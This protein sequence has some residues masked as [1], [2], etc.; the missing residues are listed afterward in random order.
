LAAVCATSGLTACL[1]TG[2]RV[3]L[4]PASSAVGFTPSSDY[5][6]MTW[7]LRWWPWSIGHGV[8]PFETKLLW[9]PQGF[10]TFW[11]TTIPVPSLLASPLTLTAGPLVAYNVLMLAAI[12]LAAG[13][14][15]LLCIE[16]TG[17]FW[18]SFLGGLAF[19]LCPYMLGHTAAQHLNLAFVFPVPLLVLVA[20]RYARGRI[21]AARFTM[22]FALLLLVLLGC[23][24]ELFVDFAVVALLASIVVALRRRRE[25]RVVRTGALIAAAYALC[26]PVI[27]PIAVLAFSS[28][29]A[30]LNFPTSD[31][32]IDLLNVLVPTP[33]LLTGGLA[34]SHTVTRNF[35]GNLGE[36]DGYL[37][38]PLL[39]VALLAMRSQ[40][41]R[42]SDLLGLMLLGTLILSFGPLLEVG[43]RAVLRIPFSPTRLPILDSALPDRMSVFSALAASCLAALWFAGAQSRALRLGVASLVVV[44]L[45]PNFRAPVAVPNAWGASN[46]FS[47]ATG[48]VTAGFVDRPDWA[49]A[50]PRGSRILVLPTGD[51]TPASYWQTA[52]QMGFA[53]AVPATPFVPPAIAGNP[54][55]RGMVDDNLWRLEGATLGGARLRAY[56]L[57]NQIS[58]VVVTKAGRS[59]WRE[60]V[61]RATDAVA[62]PLGPVEVYRVSPSLR[63][64]RATG[65]I[66]SGRART[67]AAISAWLSFDG[68]RAHVRAWLRNPDGGTVP[69][70]TLSSPDADGGWT[71]ASVNAH[72]RAAVA[73]TEWRPGK[74][75]LR[76]A[77]RGNRAWRVSTLDTRKESIFS[78]QV[79]VTDDGAV[80]VAWIGEAK[81]LRSIRVATITPDGTL[82]RPLTLATSDGLGIVTLRA[83]RDGRGGVLAW[84]D[85]IARESRVRIASSEGTGGWRVATIARTLA[86]IDRIALTEDATLVRWHLQTAGR[87]HAWRQAATT[88]AS[89]APHTR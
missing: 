48:N 33:T 67:G 77:D 88:D 4:H 1:L 31:Y 38:V 32:S 34:E 58:A 11:M 66:A 7:S 53:L 85:S 5:Q 50:V 52:A 9:P 25:P 78:P 15:Y 86:P 79:A 74:T 42:G 72:G 41:R 2:S 8:N 19:G 83:R 10:S 59:H 63:P 26:L 82:G 87:A 81:P 56:L 61:A 17:R 75:V 6:I 69:T 84:T 47:W 80:L 44:S 68:G 70:V 71:A 30:R 24:F 62:A 3:L 54:L 45:V 64:L 29:H 14:A 46:H 35:V 20:I 12:P 60:I 39:A 57:A 76:L 51:R 49:K 40:R 37:G 89:V 65:G 23:S 43:G 28:P 13:A 27:V 18:P 16:L 36:Q 22:V 73:F 55:M 21:S